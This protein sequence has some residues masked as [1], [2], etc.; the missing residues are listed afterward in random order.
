MTDFMFLPAVDC[1]VMILSWNLIITDNR[2]FNNVAPVV[3]LVL[4]LGNSNIFEILN[5]HLQNFHQVYFEVKHHLRAIDNNCLIFLHMLKIIFALCFLNRNFSKAL[6]WTIDYVDFRQPSRSLDVYLSSWYCPK[7]S[8]T[9]RSIE[10]PQNTQLFLKKT[11]V[12]GYKPT[13]LP[14]GLWQTH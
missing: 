1:Q 6:H 11:L 9:L 5:Y 13:K 12:T 4:L 2:P 7:T 14:Q 3:I 8:W 10:T